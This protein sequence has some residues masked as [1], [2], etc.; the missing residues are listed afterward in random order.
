M[1]LEEK[2]YWVGF[3]VFEGIGPLRFK[4]L[5]DYFGSAKNGYSASE[6]ELLSVGLS[7]KLVLKFLDFR[8]NFDLD[9]YLLRLDKLGIKAICSEEE[10]YPKLL[11]EIVD[12]P[13]V[14]YVKTQDAEGPATIFTNFNGAGKTQNIFGNEAIAVVGTR[15]VTGYGRQVT[16]MIT[17]GLV[18]AG[19]VVVSGLA[20]GVDKI[21]H[22]TALGNNGLTIAVLGCGLDLVYPT[23]H[24]GLAER[25]IES[26]GA[27]ISEYP[28]GVPA[29]PGNFPARNRIIS[30]LSLGVVVTEAAEDSGSLI[31]ASNAAEQGR[32]VF[33]VPGP[34]TSPLSF[35]TAE[36]IKKGAKL[37]RGVNDILEELGIKGK[38]KG[39]EEIGELGTEER[40][41]FDLLQ[42]ENLHIDEICRRTQ[43]DSAKIGALLSIM[44]IKGIIKNFGE[45]V[46]GLK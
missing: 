9:S 4:L 42:N 37:V 32:E 14:L 19:L 25:I 40:M 15:K 6:K 39:V 44:E 22:E 43:T 11:K 7:E 21:S 35:G 5:L 33:A 36:L 41:L 26:G 18:A 24:Q 8:K 45:G 13:A 30:G 12:K 31:T 17:E 28:L 3:S 16:E 23:E 1:D 20:R 46:Y 10:S 29:M 38:A 34:I 2:K 27:V